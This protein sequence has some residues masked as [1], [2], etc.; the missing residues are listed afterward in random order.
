MELHVYDVERDATDEQIW[1]GVSVQHLMPS[2]A[3]ILGL[4]CTRLAAIQ[5]GP[6]HE[7]PD[8]LLTRVYARLG[9]KQQSDAMLQRCQEVKAANHKR[10]T[11]A[12]PDK[13]RRSDQSSLPASPHHAEPDHDQMETWPP[14]TEQTLV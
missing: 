12:E 5:Y 4:G 14:K 7:S 3:G 11:K 10:P 8:Y 13:A 6:T 1:R 2:A 9:E